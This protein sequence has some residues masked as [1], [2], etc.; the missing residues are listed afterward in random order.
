[1]PKPR[2]EDFFDLIED[3]KAIGP[4]LKGWPNF[5]PLDDK[6][7]TFYCHLSYRWVACW[8]ILSDKTMELEI[9]YVGS[10]EKAPY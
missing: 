7:N 10:R 8:K 9:Y 3:L 2:Q 6:K 5:S 1:M 4:I